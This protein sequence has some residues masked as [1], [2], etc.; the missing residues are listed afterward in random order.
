MGFKISGYVL[1]PP[2]IGQSNSPFTNSPNTIISDQPAFDVAYPADES[3]PRDD[4]LVVVTQEG[5]PASAPPPIV[6]GGLL[7]H[8]GF[9]WTKNEVIN[10]F[11][12]KAQDGQF[13]TLPG[14][15]IFSPGVLGPD[16][17]TNGTR[18]I[19]PPPAEV[20]AEAPF[21]LSLSTGS[22]SGTTYTV[23]LVA[24]FGTP[25]PGNAELDAAT[26]EL[27]WNPAD[28]TANQGVEVRWQQQQFFAF[29]KSTGNIG[30][31]SEPTVADEPIPKSPVLVLN[32]LP[33]SG[34]FP[35]VRIGYSF[36]L[37][38]VEVA[39]EA[40]F[41]VYPGPASGTVEWAADTGA[42]SFNA[43]DVSANVGITIY[44]DGV[45]FAKDL[46]LPSQT[47]GTVTAPGTIAGLPSIGGDLVFRLP[48]S[49]PYY[50]FPNF[51]YVTAFDPTGQ[52]GVVQIIEGTGAVQ[53]SVADQT[54]FG[55]QDVE[56]V[57]GDLEIEHGVTLR[58][59]RSV[60]NLD[61][62]LDIKD[63]TAIYPV[64]DATW[65]SPVIG[66]PEVFLPSVPVDD[67]LYDDSQWQ[68]LTGLVTGVDNPDGRL[69]VQI[70]QG[71]GTYTGT[72]NR[73]DV[74]SPTPGLGYF[75]NFD[76]RT[77]NYAQRKNDEIIPIT[78]PSGDV[79]LTDPLALGGNVVLELESEPGSGVYVP[80]TLGVDALFDPLPALV[81]FTNTQGTVLI[82]GTGS[83][84]SGVTFT[85]P[86]AL[87][88]DP[89]V[90]VQPGDLLV[91]QTTAAKGVYTVVTVST[92]ILTTD[93]VAQ[94]PSVTGPPVPVSVVN[95][96]YSIQRGSEVLAD[97]FWQEAVL[98]DPSTK[99]ERIRSLGTGANAAPLVTSQPGTFLDT[100]TLED[101]GT[102]FLAA[103][104]AIGD[105]VRIETGPDAGSARTIT[106]AAQNQLTVAAASPFVLPLV[107][108]TYSVER[109]LRVPVGDIGS[110]RF[111]F[112]DATGANFS[113]SVVQVATDSAF[114]SPASGVVEASL[115]TGN[116]NFAAA[117][118][119][120]Q[121][122]WVRGLTPKLDYILQP[123]LGLISFTDR[124]LALEEVLVTYT[125]RPPST[126]PPTE[127]GPPKTEYATFI[128][129]KEVTA[130][131]PAPTSIL[132]FNPL[133]RPVADLPAPEVFRGGRPQKTNVQVTINATASTM[134]FLGDD[135][136]TDA[137][138]HG[139]IIAPIE[140][141]YID[142]YVLSAIGGEQTTTVLEPPILTAEVVIR[143]GDSS[144]TVHFDQTAVFRAN[145]LMR[146]EQEETYLI[147]SSTYDPVE[148]VT[149]VTLDGQQEF[150]NDFNGPTLY[151]SSGEI[152]TTT[153]PLQPS[154][155][156]PELQ[157][158][159]PIAR[160]MNRLFILGDRTGS[161]LT[162]TVFYAQAGAE[163]DYIPV[164]GSKYDPETN[165][166][167]VTLASPALRQYVQGSEILNH[168]VRPLFEENTTQVQ[169]S[170]TPVLSLPF[171]VYRRK[172]GEAGV[173]LSSPGDY[174][175]NDSGVIVF[176]QALLPD[177]EF[178][179][180]YTS[181]TVVEAGLNLRASWTF[182]IAPNDTNG[183]AGQVLLADYTIFAPD[184]FYYRVETLTNFR[185]EVAL[186]IAA[187][188]ASATP[189]SGPQTSNLSQPQLF[190]QGRES[191]FF[192]EGHLANQDLIARS[193]LLFY[194]DV[195]NNLEDVVQ[196][197]D[198]RVVGNNDGRFLFD[199][200]TGIVVT[201]GDPVFNQIDDTVKISDAPYELTGPPFAVLSIGTFQQI[202]IAGSLS[203]FFKTARNFF[204]IT[205]AGHDSGTPPETGAEIADTGST[206]LTLVGNL[207][208]RSAFAVVGQPAPI[209]ATVL[210]VDEAEGTSEFYRPP[211]LVGME[212]AILDRD[213]TPLVTE[214][215]PVT[216]TAVAA[217]ELT[218]SALTA[219]IPAGST[220]YRSSIDASS[221]SDPDTLT[222]YFSGK[223]YNY[224]PETGQIL[225]VKAY[226]PFD[227]TGGLDPALDIHEFPEKQ[228]L[229]GNLTL[230]ST[231][232][233]PNRVPMLDG[234]TVDD[235]GDLSFPIQ[236]PSPDAESS[237]AGGYVA[238]ELEVVETGGTLRTAT[239]PPY[240][241]TG[242]AVLSGVRITDV[243]PYVGDLP[244]VHDLVRILDGPNGDGIF[245]RITAV[246]ANFV[247]VA[248]S[249]G[250]PATD[251]SFSYEIAVSASTV[252]GTCDVGCTTT[253]LD[254]KAGPT[255]LSTVTVGQTVVVTSGTQV[256]HR[257]Q[258]T[259]ILSDTSLAI[260]A[261]PGAPAD[262]DTFKVDDSLATYGGTPND[263]LTRWEN[264]LLGQQGLYATNP[265]P[266]P[267]TVTALENFFDSIFTDIVVASNGSTVAATKTL[268]GGPFDSSEISVGD[269]VY[270]RNGANQGI[271][272]IADV[273]PVPAGTTLEMTE[274]FP[275]TLG[276]ISYRVVSA[277]GVS[278]ASMDALFQQ[279][280]DVEALVAGVTAALAVVQTV[281]GVEDAA[282]AAEPAVFARATQTSDLNTRETALLARLAALPAAISE[283]EQV[284]ANTDRLYDAR[285]V[286]IDARIN[287]QSGLLVQQARAVGERIQ[288]QD[289]V[290]KQLTK[291]LAVEGA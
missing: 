269:F 20:L 157:A 91:V 203:R 8:A 21:R 104:V 11:D 41:T 185:G 155:F 93:V 182:S 234:G 201:P 121:V 33:A 221:Q 132:S 73:L 75:I 288:T 231:V 237:D 45:L 62:Q 175:L 247:D 159:E 218:V 106:F 114:G 232:T 80:L 266:P 70:A 151:V 180:L 23:S 140:R 12:Y 210:Y 31:L 76:T 95:P 108:E 85:D 36:Y 46:Q 168:S 25:G 22:G 145:Y 15:A 63:V 48:D 137:L 49:D 119:P 265:G 102:D 283:V 1:E 112:G 149:T 193:T 258:V 250:F 190:Q 131:H 142:Y 213:G 118:I 84:F 3:E 199:G 66:S 42:L 267:D 134:T 38:T 195:V 144:F 179:I 72:L 158:F 94:T 192:P 165:K 256:G 156:V 189:S 4:Y 172:E 255:F 248:I 261:L 90:D 163:T 136:V 123:G 224:N 147:G 78:T 148:D 100:L 77:F 287:I 99:V 87:F 51:S 14:G 110:S 205:A 220:V 125:T 133:G 39:T 47:L 278:K 167:E 271:Y 242:G 88:D 105:T 141:V 160:G 264:D 9:G 181:N 259:A 246:G 273:P 7:E 107:N 196:N 60:I 217:G 37:D 161:Y 275:A 207:R 241:G 239:T 289:D 19:V 27:N 6:K 186:E 50:R 228:L 202:Y 286:W 245:R 34:Q 68:A 139:S 238:D 5:W 290:L 54:R 183:L 209:G 13:K 222:N 178:T 18:L 122:F 277:F 229:S 169:T 291:L 89:A 219:T 212:V 282:G 268:T 262:F 109:R 197:Y 279:M 154:Y 214:A 211:F 44:Q 64:A 143:D 52:T 56:L 226:P 129:R 150:Q 164:T 251:G 223:D 35:L 92:T 55:A 252:T 233:E 111:R 274:N 130:D 216:V 187:D 272:E 96:T 2:R 117:D 198:G 71:Q 81:T 138:P 263:E 146:I 59:F 40:A 17:N 227:G 69:A 67:S 176:T 173:L 276:G 79:Y 116:L 30:T 215:A 206:N 83:T 230:V 254:A 171:E 200:T 284:M 57:F 24:V 53:F 249:G 174:T 166:T 113:S 29:D 43:G 204:A 152:R 188:A 253:Q 128:V 270:I 101:L 177:E 28:H 257:R 16:T 120:V 244:Q 58:M 162:G 98:V 208:T 240:F 170:S 124:L 82:E 135:I 127:P 225:Y 86:G 260:T 280:L 126:S 10:R 74:A 194:N 243:T 184:G 65:A 103:S 235:D 285:F 115:E 281:V 153:A 26:G 97:R 61:G 236:S 191:L 32:P